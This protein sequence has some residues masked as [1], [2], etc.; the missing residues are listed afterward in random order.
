MSGDWTK[1]DRRSVRRL[2][3]VAW[4]RELR[5][6]LHQIAISIQEME[7]GPLSPF[8]VNDNIHVFH[9]GASRDL[10][11]RYSGADPW[12]GVCYAYRNRILTDEDLIDASDEFCNILRE[13][14]AGFSSLDAEEG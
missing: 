9:N 12:L 5:R 3:D 13:H 1:A 2:A 8:A 6:E 4:Q 7:D 11:R 10:Y 14:A